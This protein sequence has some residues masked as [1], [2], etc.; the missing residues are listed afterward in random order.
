MSKP[1]AIPHWRFRAVL[2]AVGV[3]AALLAV[4]AVDL[5]VV[6]NERYQ[7]KGDAAHLRTVQIPAHRGMITDRNGEPLA[8]S[9]PVASIWAKPSQAL[10]AVDELP[11]LAQLLGTS[12]KRL[13]DTLESRV[14]R[15]FV[16]LK[17]RVT[18][19]FAAAAESLGIAGVSSDREFRRYYPAAEVTAHLLGFT[20]V[21][22]VG[23]EGLELVFDE[24]LKGQPGKKKVLQD[25]RGRIIAEL[26]QLETAVEG[27][28]LALSID[29]RVQYLAYR[30]LKSAV[31]S[32]QARSGSLVILDTRTGE[33][34]AMVN[35]PSFN[36]NTRRGL[37]A[38][39]Y[40]NRA[41]TDVFE[42][43]ST[44]KPF[45]VAAALESGRYS[46]TSIVETGPG[47][48]YVGRHAVND[49]HD[50]GRIDVTTVL[51][52]SSNVGVAKLALGLDRNVV[53]ES[54]ARVGFGSV[55]SSSFP[56]EQ[57]GYIKDFHEWVPFEHATFSY[58]YGMSSTVLQLAR[59]YAV[60]ANDGELKPVSLLPVSGAT[61]GKRVMTPRVARQVRAML[62]TVVSDE[63]TAPKA[64]VSGYRVAGKTGTVKKLENGVYTEDKYLSLFAGIV[65]ASKPRLAVAIVIDEPRRGAYY[66]GSVAAPVFAE[67][68]GDA[69]RLLDIPPDDL[70]NAPRSVAARSRHAALAAPAD[71]GAL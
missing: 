55:T 5:Q 45:I 46:P 17:R 65:P 39:A 34:L 69:L 43:G 52:K 13:V 29:K 1:A 70:S 61:E 37:K 11:Q 31:Q 71:R 63:G 66:G 16:Y 57:G 38:S 8:I 2:T 48:F 64:R 25:R 4:R 58:G 67:V 28:D 53:W 30:A 12:P 20:N 47:R 59:A 41:V 51:T 19:E 54:L 18:P 40:R 10:E 68:M 26:E 32:H 22:D 23:Q 49:I 21:D 7:I 35:Q 62:E 50:Y 15:D 9:T 33:V 14:D 44:V 27:R 42:P 6:N 36:P 60:L 24:Y 56:G 3:V